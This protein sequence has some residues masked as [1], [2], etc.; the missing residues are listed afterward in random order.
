MPFAWI[1]QNYQIDA[2]QNRLLVTMRTHVAEPNSTTAV[3]LAGASIGITGTFMGA[4]PG[5]TAA[6][7]VW[8]R[9]L[10]IA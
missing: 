4:R 9:V 8:L 3:V 1:V 7:T 5:G 2:I 10:E 6:R